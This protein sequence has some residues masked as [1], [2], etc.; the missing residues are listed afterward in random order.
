MDISVIIPV[1]NAEDF[2]NRCIDSVLS[3]TLSKIEIICIDDC[4]TD[5]SFA[6]LQKY[7]ENDSRISC[8]K[9]EINIGQGLTRNKGIDLARG[10]YIAFVDCD[11]WIEADMYEVLYSKTAVEKYDLICCNLSNDFPNGFSGVP[12]MPSKEL[13]SLEFLVLESLAPSI[14]FFSPNSPCDKIFKREAIENLK[15]RFESERTY[16]YEDKIFNLIFLASN[17][18]IFFEP[19]VFYHYMIRY[20]STMTSYRKDF[21]ARYFL[22]DELVQNILRE[23]QLYCQETA[24]R[25]RESLFEITFVFCLNE[26]VYNKSIKGKISGFRALL[27]DKRISSNVKYFKVSDIMASSSK[28]NVL[29]KT[30]CFILLKYFR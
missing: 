13:I 14:K 12:E 21:V 8:F 4:S 27:N 18:S 24:Q 11:D 25:L 29:V 20:G 6:I 28:I 15:L 23:N 16:L 10:E 19:R 7:A 2:L 1:H 26:L 17:P 5:N 30:A 22:M 3:Q 9:N